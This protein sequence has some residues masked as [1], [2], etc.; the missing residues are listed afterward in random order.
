MY[1]VRMVI[2]RGCRCCKLPWL[3]TSRNNHSFWLPQHPTKATSSPQPT[4]VQFTNLPFAW[5]SH[6]QLYKSRLGI[7]S[8]INHGLY[9]DIYS[10]TSNVPY[11]WRKKQADI[12]LKIPQ[13]LDLPE[14]VFIHFSWIYT[15]Q[16]WMP[17]LME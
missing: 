6:N 13:F 12:L 16:T 8:Y 14:S 5:F 2:S 1:S 17:L 15:R 10:Y 11:K 7:Y 9:R 3:P 4:F